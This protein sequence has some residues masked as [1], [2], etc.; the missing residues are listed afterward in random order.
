[1]V[2]CVLG[3]DNS[4]A[5]RSGPRALV[6]GLSDSLTSMASRSGK[7]GLEW[8]HDSTHGHDGCFRDSKCVS[9]Y[10]AIN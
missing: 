6:R 9:K 3:D 1:M 5:S 4:A 8:D 7:S 10:S 2:P